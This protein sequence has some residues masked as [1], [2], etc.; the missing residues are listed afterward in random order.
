M[1]R[2]AT[3]LPVIEQGM[4]H[5]REASGGRSAME[6]LG[7]RLEVRPAAQLLT[8]PSPNPFL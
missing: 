8:P 5:C 1:P 4:D 3:C 6:D 7:A 2:E